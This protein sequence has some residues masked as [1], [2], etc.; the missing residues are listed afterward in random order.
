M[1]RNLAENKKPSVVII[2][3]SNIMITVIKNAKKKIIMLKKN[4][5]DDKESLVFLGQRSHWSQ[6]GVSLN[7]THPFLSCLQLLNWLKISA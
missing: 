6:A 4:L 1:I 7:L 5:A 3:I 2:I